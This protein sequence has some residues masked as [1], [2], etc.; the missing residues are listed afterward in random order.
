MF[1]QL[2]SSGFLPTSERNRAVVVRFQEE[3]DDAS[4]ESADDNDV[5]DDELVGVI[6]DLQAVNAVTANR[7]VRD[8]AQAAAGSGCALGE[9][10][11]QFAPSNVPMTSR[12]CCR[13]EC[14]TTGAP[15]A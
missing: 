6:T 4:S 2:M 10:I 7:P 15:N 9:F 12:S 14:P 11:E 13:V 3:Q 1:S 5:P 8:P